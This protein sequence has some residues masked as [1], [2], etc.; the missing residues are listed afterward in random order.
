M[1]TERKFKI[2]G[3][4]DSIN[5]C[6]CCG[7]TDLKA[8][9][10]VEMIESGEILHYGSVCVKRNT[11]IKNVEAAAAAYEREQ[12]A[13]AAKELRQSSEW[14]QQEKAFAARQALKNQGVEMTFQEAY[15]MVKAECVAVDAKKAELMKKY[16][17][18]NFWI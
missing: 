4:D 10:T 8:T 17:L 15:G 1:M 11:G 14:H 3:T 18:K 13:K 7:K 2:L 9:W 12:I 6:D 5:T 16:N